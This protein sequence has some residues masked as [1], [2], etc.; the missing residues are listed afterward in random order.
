LKTLLY[1][2]SFA[3]RGININGDDSTVRNN[4]R[5]SNAGVTSSSAGQA[6]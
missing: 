1:E 5:S 3:C 2:L 4:E 6:T